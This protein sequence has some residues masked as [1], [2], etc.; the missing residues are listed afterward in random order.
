M[1][2]KQEI[3]KKLINKKE[4]QYHNLIQYF[5]HKNDEELEKTITFL[6]E[7]NKSSRVLGFDTLVSMSNELID[8]LIACRD[9]VNEDK[10]TLLKILE[11]YSYICIDI[12][13]IHNELSNTY[14]ID[15]SR[16]LVSGACCDMRQESILVVDDD[17]IL[18]DLLE[19][20]L[21]QRGYDVILCSKTLNLIKTIKDN[22]IDLAIIDLVMPQIDG[23]EIIELIRKT[24]PEMPIIILSGKT[25]TENKT[26]ALGIG[27]DDYITK[28]F[29][30]EE[31]IARVERALTRA[32]NFKEKSI[33]DG[34]TGAYTKA[35]LWKKIEEYKS[36]FNRSK[37]AFSV[38]FLDLDSFKDINDNYGHLIGDE[39]LKCFVSTLKTSL[40]VTDYVFR[41]GGDEFIILFPETEEKEAYN[42]LERFRSCIS[43]NRCLEVNTGIICLSS[44]SAGIT[45]IENCDDEIEDIINRADKALYNA[46]AQGKNRSYL[47]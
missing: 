37:K 30:E 27:A 5:L 4:E 40:R 45:E 31:L 46:K 18:L 7:L 23:Y 17:P 34:L 8:H 13:K 43:Y 2:I 25:N 12:E 29:Q 21:F 36:L 28:P 11:L 24:E 22:K 6:K 32:L 20:I 10:D 42:V 16:V 47:Y 9:G 39:V 35:F 14:L 1:D 26:R 38:A 15:Q 3:I 41:F 19:K 44:F 33:E